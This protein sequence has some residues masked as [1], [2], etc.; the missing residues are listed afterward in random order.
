MV[1]TPAYVRDNIHVSLLARAYGNFAAR[2]ADGVSR[3]RPSGYVESQGA[4][5][6]RVAN[7]MQM[8]LGL[9]CELEIKTQTEFLE[10]CVRINTDRL[11]ANMLKWNEASA[12]NE[13]ANY[14]G[15]MTARHSVCL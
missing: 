4:F 9:R 3:Y 10:P 1:R 14:Y 13:I 8:Q 15:Q 6:R 2:L 5:A 12:W 7:E 11:D